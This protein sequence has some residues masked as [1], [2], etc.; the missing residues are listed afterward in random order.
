MNHD[1]YHAAK[2]STFIMKIS[3]GNRKLTLRGKIIDHVIFCGER[4]DLDLY[5]DMRFPHVAYGINSIPDDRM[6][7]MHQLFKILKSWV[8]IIQSWVEIIH[9]SDIYPTGESVKEALRQTL[10]QNSVEDL[11]I[12]TWYDI[13][14]SSDD[15]IMK[16]ALHRI[17]IVGS[18]IEPPGVH[19]VLEAIG[20]RIPEET[21]TFYAIMHGDSGN[22]HTSAYTC[23]RERS[24]FI[25]DKGFM[26]S[27]PGFVQTGDEV[28]LFSAWIFRYS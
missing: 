27:A 9:C 15:N 14:T 17:G 4:L 19:R 22:F 11:S 5:Q 3:S 20:G 13:I 6:R 10:Q 8:H 25:T 28:A 21:R 24:L 7:A 18:G 2:A 16:L 12:D 26:G 23:S 1:R